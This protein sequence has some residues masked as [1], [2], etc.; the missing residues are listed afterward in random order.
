MWFYAATVA[1][2]AV[3][4]RVGAGVDACVAAGLVFGLLTYPLAWFHYDA[5]LIP[6]LVWMVTTAHARGRTP[7]VIAAAL[8]VALR[9]VPNMQGDQRLQ[10]WFQVAAR[11]LLGAGVLMAAWPGRSAAGREP[12]A[13]A[14][15]PGRS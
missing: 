13:G 11:A 2:V 5:A 3:A 6:V 1:G 10:Q 12:P 7:A 4:R 8:F 14:S 9:A 15:A